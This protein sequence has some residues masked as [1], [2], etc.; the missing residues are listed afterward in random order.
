MLSRHGARYPTQGSHV[1][2]LGRRLE[3]AASTFKASGR[4]EFLNDWKYELGAEILVPKG[5]L[6]SELCFVF[7]DVAD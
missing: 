3:D 4:L 7:G 6:A 1:E 5:R 2:Q